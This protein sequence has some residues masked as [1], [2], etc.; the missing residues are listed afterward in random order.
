MGC[1]VIFSNHCSIDF[2]PIALHPHVFSVPGLRHAEMSM[3]VPVFFTGGILGVVRGRHAA[4]L[5]IKV[6]RHHTFIATC[7]VASIWQQPLQALLDKVIA[8]NDQLQRAL[9]IEK[10]IYPGSFDTTV[11]PPWKR[12]SN[13]FFLFGI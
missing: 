10:A 4:P 13:D 11:E 2:R 6:I 1:G 3:D 9:T 7:I 12:V 5:N 8:K